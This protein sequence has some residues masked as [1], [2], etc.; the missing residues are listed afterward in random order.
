M[1][2]PPEPGVPSS[3]RLFGV[4]RDSRAAEMSG[5]ERSSARCVFARIL[6]D[7]LINQTSSVQSVDSM[8][9]NTLRL[10]SLY[11]L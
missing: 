6:G 5:T 2:S 8:T 9:L 3:F 10:R 1:E 4:N 7:E 11:G